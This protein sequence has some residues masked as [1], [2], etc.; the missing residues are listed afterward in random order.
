MRCSALWCAD[1]GMATHSSKV[2]HKTGP[3]HLS[4]QSLL[5]E[6]GATDGWVESLT[7][8]TE[9][10]Q[11]TQLLDEDASQVMVCLFTPCML[12]RTLCKEAGECAA[13]LR[14][15]IPMHLWHCRTTGHLKMPPQSAG[16]LREMELK[17][18]S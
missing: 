9:A 11:A 13:R 2:A 16:L 5:K 8:L 4:Q 3:H 17:P 14:M 18:A 1:I 7:S 15:M 12:I 10:V 6:V